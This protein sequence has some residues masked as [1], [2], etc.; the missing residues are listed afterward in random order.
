MAITSRSVTQLPRTETLGNQD[1]M[2]VAQG[3]ADRSVSLSIFF[4]ALAN[5][6][7]PVGIVE[8]FSRGVDPNA[9]FNGQKWRRMSTGAGC[10]IRTANETGTDINQIGGEDVIRLAEENLPAHNHRIDLQTAIFGSRRIVTTTAGWH[11]HGAGT[12][13]AGDHQHQD[14]NYAPGPVYASGTKGTNNQ[15]YFS[16]N[17]T[18]WAGNHAHSI[19]IDYNGVHSHLVNLGAHSHRYTGTSGN[20]GNGYTFAVRNAYAKLIFW[21]RES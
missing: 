3:T 9:I 14:G 2:H 17:L 13:Y 18:S 11:A 19:G 20:K 10:T 7:Y 12:S 4:R 6:I 8:S 15:G 21:T 5:A 16:Q 1:L